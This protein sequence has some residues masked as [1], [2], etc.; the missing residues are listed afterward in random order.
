MSPLAR[1]VKAELAEAAKDNPVLRRR[2]GE[3]YRHPLSIAE[4]RRLLMF[5]MQRDLPE[6]FHFLTLHERMLDNI[7]SAT[8][9]LRSAIERLSKNIRSPIFEP[10]GDAPE[11]AVLP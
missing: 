7:T 8:E 4:S 2:L 1:A 5:A 11:S 9:E 3:T 10:A 6:L